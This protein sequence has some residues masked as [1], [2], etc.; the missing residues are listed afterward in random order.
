[1]TDAVGG[2]WTDSGVR[3]PAAVRGQG[4][5]K[6]ERP[7]R[8]HF[9]TGKTGSSTVRRSLSALLVDQLDLIPVPRNLD[10]RDGSA[11]FA[12]DPTGDAPERLDGRAAESGNLGQA[13]WLGP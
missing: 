13:R 4:G 7:R 12:L 8:R 1:M 6:P 2:A 9:A 5:G 11:N 3:R 10:N